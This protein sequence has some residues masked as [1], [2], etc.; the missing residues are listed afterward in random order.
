[1]QLDYLLFDV[2]DEE[3]GGASFDALASVLPDRLPALLREA[4][5]VLQWA[6]REFGPPSPADEGGWDFDL[7]GTG[8]TGD[9]LDFTYDAASARLTLRQPVT[10]RITL[11][12]TLGGPATFCEAF[13]GAF[14]DSA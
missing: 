1:M 4:E 7:Q 6:H 10:G 12:L 8:E 14:P 2:T 9:I 5:A 13:R 3:S 11:S